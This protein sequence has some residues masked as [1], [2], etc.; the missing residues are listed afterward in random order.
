M[1][2][3]FSFPFHQEWKDEKLT[4]D[5]ADYNGLEVMR[6]PCRKIWLPD[7][8]LYNRCVSRDNQTIARSVN[9]VN[10]ETSL[11]NIVHKLQF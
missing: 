3:R 5:P 8:V 4:W 6:I 10:G 9:T 2:D 1:T 7:I 11:K